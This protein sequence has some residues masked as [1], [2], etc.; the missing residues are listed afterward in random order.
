MY[1]R[2]CVF[3]VVEFASSVY[4]ILGEANGIFVY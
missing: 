1:R 2:R 4:S 3:F